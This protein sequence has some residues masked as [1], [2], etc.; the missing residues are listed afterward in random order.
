MHYCFFAA[1]LAIGTSIS[2]GQ[3]LGGTG[4]GSPAGGS[5]DSP[6]GSVKIVSVSPVRHLPIGKKVTL[7][8]E[9]EDVASP[10]YMWDAG[11]YHIDFLNL[12]ATRISGRESCDSAPEIPNWNSEV[13]T[14]VVSVPGVQR[15]QVYL[16]PPNGPMDSVDVTFHA[17]NAA[18]LTITDPFVPHPYTPL[19][20]DDD[21]FAGDPVGIP[22]RPQPLQIAQTMKTLLKWDGQ[23]L[24]KCAQVCFKEK[25]RCTVLVPEYHPLRRFLRD[26]L[27]FK[28]DYI[29][30][31]CTP[32]FYGSME[33]P[34]RPTMEWAS[35]NLY[36]LN[37]G[38]WPWDFLRA[39]NS[40]RGDGF[41]HYPVGTK[42]VLKQHE[43][44]F[45]GTGCLGFDWNL[46]KTFWLELVVELAEDANGLPI[47]IPGTSPVR[48]FKIPKWRPTAAP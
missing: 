37:W 38:N 28:D 15:Y 14:D 21:P 7:T 41:E 9:A 32:A 29:P 25:V 30:A 10:T 35:P 42:L 27:K 23:E 5:G 36:D 39:I 8:A 16:N 48:N 45:Y 13:I 2:Y 34:N 33:D 46:H 24:G 40:V 12:T 26:F 31:N 4:S 6:R 11:C 3:R 17:P 1:F 20:P 43:Y 19:D 22:P 18:E 44:V 47:P